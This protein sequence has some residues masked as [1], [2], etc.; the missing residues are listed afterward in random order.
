MGIMVFGL[1]FHGCRYR[2]RLQV[3]DFFKKNIKKKFVCGGDFWSNLNVG[4]EEI[5]ESSLE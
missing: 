2:L 4:F 1:G 5:R 3:V